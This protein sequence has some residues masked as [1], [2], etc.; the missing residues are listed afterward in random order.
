MIAGIGTSSP[1]TLRICGRQWMDI[2]ELQ[3]LQRCLDTFK[4]LM[5]NIFLRLKKKYISLFVSLTD[6]VLETPGSFATFAI[7]SIRNL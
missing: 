4:S 7:S 3:I 1:T 6:L 2:C 5:D